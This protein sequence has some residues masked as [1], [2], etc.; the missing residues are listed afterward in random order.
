MPDDFRDDPEIDVERATVTITV[1]GRPDLLAH[2]ETV[3]I[4]PQTVT[5]RYRSDRPG[6]INA[7]VTGPASRVPGRRYYDFRSRDQSAHYYLGPEWPQWPDWLTEL[8]N[9]HRPHTWPPT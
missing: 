8:G 9:Q 2:G 4:T 6:A 3:I 5:F 7:I 1:T